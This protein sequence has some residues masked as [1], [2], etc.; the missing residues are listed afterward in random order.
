MQSST[1]WQRGVSTSSS[2]PTG[3]KGANNA[4][5]LSVSQELV[6]EVKW[7]PYRGATDCEGTQTR[8]TFTPGGASVIR[9]KPRI[10]GRCSQTRFPPPG[11]D[12]RCLTAQQRWDKLGLPKDWYPPQTPTHQ[13]AWPQGGKAAATPR[14]IPLL[15]EVCG[16]PSASLSTTKAD[17]SEAGKGSSSTGKDFR[18]CYAALLNLP[19]DPWGKGQFGSWKAI[20]C[21]LLKVAAKGLVESWRELF[22][23][24]ANRAV[25]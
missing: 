3:F 2:K 20:V 18:S 13:Q 15:G 11:T 24:T 16:L 10:W 6:A 1:T 9:I 21:L 23:Y 19:F 8:Q 25:P 14:L 7:D 12:Q 4:A 17:W 22:N 5:A